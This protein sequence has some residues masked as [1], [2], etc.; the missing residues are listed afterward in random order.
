VRAVPDLTVDNAASP[1]PECR[2]AW[3][4]AVFARYD[5]LIDEMY[6]MVRPL[7]G[8]IALAEAMHRQLGLDDSTEGAAGR[9]AA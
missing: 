7:T 4:A 1:G 8:L 3:K 2:F 5:G 9:A 6:V